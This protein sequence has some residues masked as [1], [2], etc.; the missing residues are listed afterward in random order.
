MHQRCVFEFQEEHFSHR[1]EAIARGP[2]RVF[3]FNFLA[4]GPEKTHSLFGRAVNKD[5]TRIVHVQCVPL[6]LDAEV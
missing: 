1:T 3:D 2:E 6:N 5:Y 4:T